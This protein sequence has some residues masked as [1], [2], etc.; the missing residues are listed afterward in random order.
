M[1]QKTK[2]NLIASVLLGIFVT[3][4]TNAQESKFRY[5]FSPDTTVVTKVFPSIGWDTRLSFIGGET[6]AFKGVRLGVRFGKK[7]HRLTA[8]YR[9]FS[10]SEN[11]GL[12][13]YDDLTK[14]IN[15]RY[16]NQI[17]GY[18]YTLSY[19]HIILDTYRFAFG[20]TADIGIGANYDDTLP[21]GENINIFSRKDRFTPLQLGI[22]GEFKATRFAGI[23]ALAGYRQVTNYQLQPSINSIY[24]GFGVRLYF[25]SLYR[26][27]SEPKK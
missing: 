17:D 20:A 7:S 21:F 14:P 27:F 9:W 12:L 5:F 26:H 10:F 2:Q 19:Q 1:S 4:Q 24:V 25:G 22:Y 8:A 18:F 16:F 15:P 3:Y 13:N 6:V 11:I 23:T